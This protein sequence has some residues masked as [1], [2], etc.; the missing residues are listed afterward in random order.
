M[1]NRKRLNRLISRSLLD[2]IARSLYR[3]ALAA[4]RCRELYERSLALQDRQLELS[5]KSFRAAQEMAHISKQNYADRLLA[6]IQQST[7][8]DAA[9]D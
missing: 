8:T 1:K 7:R 4:E 5:E 2:S 3:Q 9:D 6:A